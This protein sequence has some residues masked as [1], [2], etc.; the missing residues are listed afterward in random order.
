MSFFD[1][2]EDVTIVDMFGKVK[3]KLINYLFGFLG[4]EQAKN[5]EIWERQEKADVCVILVLFHKERCPVT[6]NHNVHFRKYTFYMFHVTR[7][8]ISEGELAVVSEWVCRV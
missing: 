8:E 5:H 7:P 2:I 1:K 6:K 3:V 4:E